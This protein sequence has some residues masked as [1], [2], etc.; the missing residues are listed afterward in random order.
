MCD[1]QPHWALD[2]IHLCIG[3][4]KDAIV[5]YNLIVQPVTKENG[6]EQ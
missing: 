6:E 1:Q 3:G 2:R 4:I 5:Q